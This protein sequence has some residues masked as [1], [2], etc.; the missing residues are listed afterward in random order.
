MPAPTAFGKSL[1]L[2]ALPVRRLIV[3]T[4][5][6]LSLMVAVPACADRPPEE[7]IFGLFLEDLG[8]EERQQRLAKVFQQLGREGR[9]TPATYRKLLVH[10]S[11]RM[12]FPDLHEALARSDAERAAK[13]FGSLLKNPPDL[14][15]DSRLGVQRATAYS[16]AQL[17]EANQD[18][19]LFAMLRR[20]SDLQL[21]IFLARSFSAS[22]RSEVQ[23]LAIAWSRQLDAAVKQEAEQ[24]RDDPLW[25]QKQL[26]LRQDL[27]QLLS[28]IGTAAS[29]AELLASLQQYVGYSPTWLVKGGID[30]LGAERFRPAYSL[31]R[32]V[33]LDGEE[34]LV[35]RTAALKAMA[36]LYP[37]DKEQD[38]ARVARQLLTA[39][40]G[41][42]EWPEVQAVIEA[43][44]EK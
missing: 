23:D 26:G 20:Q 40:E 30:L 1:E 12:V 35:T 5:V 6:L 10:P 3:V 9:L 43:L 11:G 41:E 39:V 21:K 27:N 38:V 2:A 36:R 16:L 37:P 33:A 34:E 13:I 8:Y 15:Y 24:A 18:D 29:L 19:Q 32:R 25:S 28:R 14:P 44:D 22:R 4:S 17:T 31:M 42:R 7:R